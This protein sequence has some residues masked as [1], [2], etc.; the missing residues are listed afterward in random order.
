M[1]VNKCSLWGREAFIV[2]YITV[3]NG[4]EPEDDKH[5]KVAVVLVS[6]SVNTLYFSWRDPKE[7]EY[8][9]NLKLL[10]KR[11]GFIITALHKLPENLHLK[12]FSGINLEKAIEWRFYCLFFRQVVNK[13]CEMRKLSRILELAL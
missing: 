11:F 6:P 10:L 1:K 8:L 7:N 9:L 2:F 13:F 4:Y 5:M 3:D 12:V